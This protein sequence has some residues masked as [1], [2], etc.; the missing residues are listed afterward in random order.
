MLWIPTDRLAVVDAA[1]LATRTLVSNMVPLSKNVTVPVGIPEPGA[2]AVTVAVNETG[3]P[4]TEG[5]TLETTV[6]VVSS[7]FTTW[8]RG[9]ALLGLRLPSPLYFAVM[10]WLPTLKL[11]VTKAAIPLPSRVTVASVVV[12]SLKVTLP[13]AV[14]LAGGT[15]TTAA[16]MVTVCPKT[17]G[18]AEELS[19]VL[20]TQVA[21]TSV[22]DV[23][24]CWDASEVAETPICRAAKTPQIRHWLAPALSVTSAAKMP[25]RALRKFGVVSVFFMPSTISSSCVFLPVANPYLD[26]SLVRRSQSADAQISPSL[27]TSQPALQSD[28]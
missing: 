16:V 22:P 9:V 11:D 25:S 4:K 18:L 28:V 12:P 26:I 19:V 24:L 6:V 3:C 10:V 17:D 1:W 13:C 7:R 21:G 14:P 15:G 2:F 5:L 20:L 23:T 27:W 8:M